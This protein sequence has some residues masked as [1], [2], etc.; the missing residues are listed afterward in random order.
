MS[1]T[2]KFAIGF[3]IASGAVVTAWL[4][5]G[6]RKQ[7]TKNFISARSIKIKNA[8]KTE[9]KSFDDSEAFYI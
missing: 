6:E 9:N 7:K 1:T 2:T 5:T 4:L 8:L 3:G